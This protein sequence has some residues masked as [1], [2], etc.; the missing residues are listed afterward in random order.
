MYLNQKKPFFHSLIQNFHECCSISYCTF[1]Y[2]CLTS[3]WTGWPLQ[4]VSS[5]IDKDMLEIENIIEALDK[6]RQWDCAL[7]SE[8]PVS[9]F[10]FKNQ[11]N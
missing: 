7:Q 4:G 10:Y 2:S 6:T 9:L 8:F 1:A 11:P 5:D 3:T